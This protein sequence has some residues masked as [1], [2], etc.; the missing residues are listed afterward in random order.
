MI[1]DL[2]VESSLTKLQNGHVSGKSFRVAVRLRQDK[3]IPLFKNHYAKMC[4][5]LPYYLAYM[6]APAIHVRVFHCNFRHETDAIAF[7]LSVK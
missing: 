6:S 2:I 3:H 4:D 7:Y 5:H 1:S